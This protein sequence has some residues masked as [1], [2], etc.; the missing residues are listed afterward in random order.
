MST[1]LDDLTEAQRQ[2]VYAAVRIL[3]E[4]EQP[5][6]RHLV[7]AVTDQTLRGALERTLAASG[8]VLLETPAGFTSGYDDTT[9]HALTRRGIG[10]LP[11]TDRAVLTLVLLWSVAIPRALGTIASEAHWTVGEPVD[12][13]MLIARSKLPDTTARAAITRLRAAGILGWGTNRWLVPGPAF[14]RL[15]ARVQE[16]LFQDLVLLAEPNGPLAE[17]IKRRRATR[18]GGALT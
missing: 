15:T 4:A 2:D 17:S 5:V 13:K 8:R 7:R 9:R 11:D 1:H 16:D 18:S 10:V 12:P 6:P 14:H 3:D